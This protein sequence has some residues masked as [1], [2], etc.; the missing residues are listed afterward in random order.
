MGNVAWPYIYLGAFY[1]IQII[2]SPKNITLRVNP[3]WLFRPLQSQQMLRPRIKLPLLSQNRHIGI[4][5]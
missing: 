4:P 1:D 3:H 2:Q 5:Q